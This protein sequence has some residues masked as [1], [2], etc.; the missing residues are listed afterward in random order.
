MTINKKYYFIETDLFAAL[1]FYIYA[2]LILTSI[3]VL[4]F[5]T[6]S[7][8]M[9]LLLTSILL[10]F[11]LLIDS[12]C[13][14]V[15]EIQNDIII[16]KLFLHASLNQIKSFEYWWNYDFHVGTKEENEEH[17]K[18][19]T[20]RTNQVIV[21]LVLKN[22]NERIA[23]Q[24][25]IRLDTRHPNDALHLEEFNNMSTHTFRIQRIDK[26]MQFLETYLPDQQW[27]IDG[28]FKK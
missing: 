26:L 19:W 25:T 11:E 13:V 10:G 4:Y 3:I 6:I 17:D 18:K 1:R 20:S 2:T 22:K 9:V 21:N 15:D 24:E 27:E 16:R 28:N 8:W 5:P 14:M 12:G 23:F 7:L